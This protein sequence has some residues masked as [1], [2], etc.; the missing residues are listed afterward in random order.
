M[1]YTNDKINM[2]LAKL[3]FMVNKTYHQQIIMCVEFIYRF[4]ETSSWNF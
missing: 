2:K 1:Q 3:K 4:H